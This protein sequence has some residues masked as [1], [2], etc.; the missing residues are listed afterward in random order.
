METH[1]TDIELSI[2]ID[3]T[4]IQIRR[5]NASITEETAQTLAAELHDI[6]SSAR[7]LYSVQPSP[8]SNAKCEEIDVVETLRRTAVN[9][10]PADQRRAANE[11]CW[12]ME[13]LTDVG[14]DELYVRYL[15]LCDSV[16]GTDLVTGLELNTAV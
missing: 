3:F 5:A 8:K 12:L 16:N 14:G 10:W 4:A 11:S 13:R 15:R 2:P 1:R 9:V 6:I 7:K